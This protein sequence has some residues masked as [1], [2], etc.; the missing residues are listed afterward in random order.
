LK[1]AGV[2]IVESEAV[3]A[4]LRR[5]RVEW[6]ALVAVLEAHPEQ[7][8]HGEGSWVSRDVYAHLVRWI[9]HSTDDLEARLAGRTLPPLEGTDDEIN[10]RWQRD[11]SGLSLAEARRLAREAFERR[12]RAIESVAPG[13]WDPVLEAIANADGAEHYANHRRYIAVPQKEGG[14][15]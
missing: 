10:E 14:R 1:P 2:D 6:E 9:Q 13:R 11:D 5:D 4:M 7:R 12:L 15:P 8:L 3:A